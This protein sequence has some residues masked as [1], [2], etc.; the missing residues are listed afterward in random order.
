MRSMRGAVFSLFVLMSLMSRYACCAGDSLMVGAGADSVNPGY[1]PSGYSAADNYGNTTDTGVLVGGGAPSMMGMNPMTLSG[2]Q[3]VNGTTPDWNQGSMMS[4]PVTAMMRAGQ[5]MG[6]GM[7]MANSMMM[8]ARGIPMGTPMPMGAMPGG[9]FMGSGMPMGMNMGAAMNPMGMGGMQG[10]MMSPQM[11]MM[12][13]EMM[14]TMMMQSPQFQKTKANSKAGIVRTVDSLTNGTLANSVP[15]TLNRYRSGLEEL[16]GIAPEYLPSDITA[17]AIDLQL[18]RVNLALT[19]KNTLLLEPNSKTLP[20]TSLRQDRMNRLN[21]LL[22]KWST[23]EGV[24]SDADR[25]VSSPNRASRSSSGLMIFIIMRKKIDGISADERRL[26]QAKKEMEE[27]KNLGTL[28]RIEN[29][30]YNTI[31]AK[32]HAY[33]RLMDGMRN[34]DWERVIDA[35]RGNELVSTGR[36]TSSR[37]SRMPKNISSQG[38]RTLPSHVRGGIS[39][40]GRDEIMEFKTEIGGVLDSLADRPDHSLGDDRGLQKSLEIHEELL[41]KV[42]DAMENPSLPNPYRSPSPLLQQVSQ[43]YR[44]LSS[45]TMREIMKLSLP[46]LEEYKAAFEAAVLNPENKLPKDIS[47]S[48]AQK[49]HDKLFVIIVTRQYRELDQS[50]KDVS[51]GS[52]VHRVRGRMKN[53]KGEVLSEVS[54]MVK[55]LKLGVLNRNINLSDDMVSSDDLMKVVKE[56]NEMYIVGSRKTKKAMYAQNDR[57]KAARMALKNLGID[58]HVSMQDL[59]EADVNQYLNGTSRHRLKGAV[60]DLRTY[61]FNQD[62]YIW[63]E[64][65]D[66]NSADVEEEDPTKGSKRRGRHKR[67]LVGKLTS[68]FTRHGKKDKEKTAEEGEEKAVHSETKPVPEK[69]ETGT[70]QGMHTL[71]QNGVGIAEIIGKIEMALAR[72]F[73]VENIESK[74]VKSNLDEAIARYREASQYRYSGFLR[75]ESQNA[76]ENYTDAL[77]TAIEEVIPQSSQI[78]KRPADEKSRTSS[79]RTR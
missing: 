63:P 36:T 78:H 68:K 8:G 29:A 12:N 13:P 46:Q 74:W 11:F 26:Y 39:Q 59:P 70:N 55:Y 28:R 38:G 60:D 32:G 54:E 37:S 5:S 35:A 9:I 19:D 66:E 43:V 47:Y 75:S 42:L 45:M 52:F 53:K 67:G 33:D 10:G 61:Y 48:K 21:T 17:D 51:Q 77:L 3:G 50:R 44:N 76:I 64:G 56:Q 71:L 41:Q 62:P 73:K 27:E 58:L 31:I 34:Q 24:R 22:A 40:F 57:R 14:K 1:I 25:R 49:M 30:L 23:P 72:K 18:A 79:R 15:S 20:D 6:S 4:P 7:P 69:E 65:F 16:A 2:M